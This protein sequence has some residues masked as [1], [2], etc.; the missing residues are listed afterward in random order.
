MVDPVTLSIA[1]GAVV[2]AVLSYVKQSSCCKG[3]IEIETQQP[4]NPPVLSIPE[5]KK[6]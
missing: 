2:V 6:T 4:A 5:Q 1:I 3:F